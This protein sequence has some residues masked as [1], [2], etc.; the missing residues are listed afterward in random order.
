[1]NNAINNLRDKGYGII[2]PEQYL[3]DMEDSF[4]TIWEQV[5]NYTMTSVERG[6]SLFKSVEYIVKNKI[7]GD[8]VECGVWKGGSCMLIAMTLDLIKDT[9]RKIYLYDTYEGMPKPT[10]EDV[11]SWNGRSVLEKWEEDKT[12]NKNNFGSWAVGMEEVKVNISKSNYPENNLIFIPGDVA[13]TLKEKK[14]QKISLL[15][16]DTDWYASTV[17]ELETLYPLLVDKG[18]LIIDDYGHFDGARKAVDEYFENRSILLNRIDYT[19]RVGIKL[20]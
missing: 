6:Y 14:P 11:I 5:H 16:L 9:N 2:P 17:E 10:E 8:F 7:P 3:S 15:R 12:G 20:N 1:M 4:I 19:G 13:Q 18:V